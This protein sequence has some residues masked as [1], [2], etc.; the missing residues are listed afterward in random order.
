MSHHPPGDALVGL[1]AWH[2]P[3]LALSL[4]PSLTYAHVLSYFAS[5]FLAFSMC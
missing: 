1:F 5:L 2:N 3:A 4:L